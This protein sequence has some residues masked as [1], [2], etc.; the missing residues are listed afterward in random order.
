MFHN[1][2]DHH[3]HQPVMGRSLV[4]AIIINILF[5]IIEFALGF[6]Y[7]SAGLLADAGHNLGDA[8][9]LLIS[10]TA[11]F[12]Q[13]LPPRGRFT[14]GLGKAT[15]LAAA[16]NGLLLLT[17]S[18]VIIVECIEKF[19]QATSHSGGAVAITAFAGILV[20]GFTVYLLAKGKNH[21]LN[22]KSA[23]LH[24]A[25]DTMVSG[26][27]L[28]SGVLIMC[29]RWQWLDPAIGLLITV[30]IVCSALKLLKESLILLLD[31]VPENIPQDKLQQQIMAIDGVADIHHFHIRAVSTTE[32]A[33]TAHVKVH[34]DS[35][36]PDIRKK[37]KALPEIS[38][39]K[40]CTLE[41]E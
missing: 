27:V 5:V 8:G 40:Y 16:I 21:D 38:R 14:Y 13:K 36:S 17:A 3:H 29:T 12:L 19:H 9:G 41:V 2:H 11:F 26:G 15:V 32:Y 7:N 22:I 33:L 37:I 31:G 23:Y 10:M 39:M 6:T 1:H 35:L 30:C 25:A 18:A 24:M 20:N 4:A 28:I 34:N